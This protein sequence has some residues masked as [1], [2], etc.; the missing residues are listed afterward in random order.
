M[1]RTTK[2]SA[3]FARIKSKHWRGRCQKSESARKEKSRNAENYLQSQGGFLHRGQIQRKVLLKRESHQT[4]RSQRVTR[5]PWGR[6]HRN[7]QCSK[8]KTEKKEKS[9]PKKRREN[10]ANERTKGD[11][12]RK[13]AL[14]LLGKRLGNWKK[15]KYERQKTE[16]KASGERRGRSSLNQG[17][18][19]GTQK[20]D[21]RSLGGENP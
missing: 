9:R 2:D 14:R 16:E 12:R 21:V 15:N 13:K 18:G 8:G 3:S 19:G 17:R 10:I 6:R 7:N 20:N 4:G 11:S 1:T 5:L